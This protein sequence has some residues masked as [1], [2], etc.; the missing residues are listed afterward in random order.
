M[1][2]LCLWVPQE[3][4]Q[5][6]H[7]LRRYC[8]YGLSRGGGDENKTGVAVKNETKLSKNKIDISNSHIHDMVVNFTGFG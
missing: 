2:H 1:G 8:V 5:R 6:A 3:T 4:A 7:A